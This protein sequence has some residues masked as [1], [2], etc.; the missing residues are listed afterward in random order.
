MRLELL[1]RSTA[2]ENSCTICF[3]HQANVT[4]YPCKHE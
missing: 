4:L 3:D 1:G 2:D